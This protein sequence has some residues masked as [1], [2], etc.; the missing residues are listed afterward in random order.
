MRRITP[1]RDLSLNEYALTLD[2]ASMKI[3]AISSRGSK[4]DFI[5]LYFLLKK[6]SL[7][8]LIGFF[9]KKYTGVKYN[10]LH[11]LK[12]LAYFS[13]ADNEPMPHMI[14]PIEWEDVKNNI[15]R[16]TNMLLI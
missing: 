14:K 15:Y 2:I 6:Y 4:K 8:E 7:A 5:D 12:S 9:E 10:R 16:E 13:D 11:I 3:D 1:C